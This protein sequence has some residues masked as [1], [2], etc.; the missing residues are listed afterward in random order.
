MTDDISRVARA[1]IILAVAGAGVP[2]ARIA[3][4]QIQFDDPDHYLLA[5]GAS[6]LTV[7]DMNND[8]WLD[9]VACERIE[10]VS[11][12]LNDG[13]GTLSRL[14][15]IYE[16]SY[17]LSNIQSADFDRDG[18]QDVVWMRSRA[19][20]GALQVMYGRGDGGEGWIHDIPLPHVAGSFALS[21][22]DGDGWVDIVVADARGSSSMV[23]VFHNERG[24]FVPGPTAPLPWIDNLSLVAG[25][26][27]GD[28]DMDLAVLSLD[29]DHDR[30]YGWKLDQC[31]VR[32][33]FNDG[34]GSFPTGGT[35]MLPYG[36][37][38]WDEDPF[39]VSLRLA[40]LD[41]DRDL[42][43]VLAAMSMANS[44]QPLEVLPIE[45]RNFAEEFVLQ[46]PLFVPRARVLAELAVGDIDTDGDIDVVVKANASLWMIENAGGLA[47]R[48]PVEVVGGTYAGPSLALA[49][50]NGNG[51][52]DLLEG[53]RSGI[54]VFTNITPYD[55]PVLEHT[56]LKRGSQSTLTV[57]DAQP[58]ERVDF[59]Y[60][61]HGT[62]NSVGIQQLGGIT[63]DLNDEIRQLGHTTADGSGTAEFHFSVPSDAPLRE[64]VMQAVI[65]RG[66][67]GEDSVKTP[68]RTARVAP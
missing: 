37:G 35:I 36:G 65:R 43:L 20:S 18:N 68:F 34:A 55:G 3:L 21:D 5:A 4:A 40:D 58:G 16:P 22:V 11:I 64:V 15:S 66:S 31:Q 47:L 8:G 48:D 17:E 49:D 50:L 1:R 63:L 53:H 14:G 19:S 57:T 23:R 28:G 2:A 62:G 30:M 24:T 9:V 54:S 29:D 32:V 52:L 26:I 60:T 39:P 13:D 25:D 46:E 41:G 10:S 56:P 42:D 38:Y 51:Q 7:T 61:F 27:D 33:L 45:N 44:Q 59:L 12:F 67:G 6:G